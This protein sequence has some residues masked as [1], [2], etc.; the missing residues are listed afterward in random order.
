MFATWNRIRRPARYRVKV[1]GTRVLLL[2]KIA[3]F[4]VSAISDNHAMDA[5][6]LARIAA[7]PVRA[8]A[9]ASATAKQNG[10]GP[11]LRELVRHAPGRCIITLG[12]ARWR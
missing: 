5:D 6:E 7:A 3:R 8:I 9:D 2:L 11:E 10:V 1:I 12:S 4:R